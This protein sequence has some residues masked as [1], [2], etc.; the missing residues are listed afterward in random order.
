M[1]EVVSLGS[2][3]VDR[4]RYLTTEEIAALAAERDWFPAA[5]E[6]RSIERTPPDL[7]EGPFENF[8]GGKAANQAVAASRAGAETALLG[9]VG[10]DASEYDVR[11]TLARRGVDV[12]P[13]EPASAPTGKA[14]IF[15]DE[16][17]ESHIAIVAGANGT[18]DEHYVDRYTNL[19]RDAD[20]LVFQNEIPTG[21]IRAVL[22]E[23]TEVP[24]GPTVI[25]DPAPVDGADAVVGHPAI[26][27]VSPNETEYAALREA[28]PETGPTV[29]QRRGPADVI[30]V[31]AGEEQFRVTPP[32]VDAVDTTGAGD[33]FNGYL[34]AALAAGHSLRSA[35]E[36]ATAAASYSTELVGAQQAIPERETL[37]DDVQPPD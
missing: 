7:P 37:P 36:W 20:A 17:G 9:K 3:N 11:D 1:V 12:S 26:D 10:E 18:V 2:I 23:L 29:I 8:L 5:G 21:G 6:T 30:V 24:A 28:I 35:V 32:A 4:T 14:F 27:I 22:E 15:V 33:V 34:A 19:I 25:F 16:T 31:E 13:V